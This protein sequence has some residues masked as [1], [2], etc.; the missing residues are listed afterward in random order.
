MNYAN[1][2][3]A[4]NQAGET[5]WTVLY[6][7]GLDARGVGRLG[8]FIMVVRILSVALLL[9]VAAVPVSAFQT[10]AEGGG[11]SNQAQS[12]GADSGKA[13]DLSSGK[14]LPSREDDK[15]AV[16]IPGLGSLGVLPKLDF[17]LELLYGDKPVAVAEPRDDAIESDP[18]GL[19][20]KGTFKHRF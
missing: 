13:L 1:C 18:D 16:R 4:F 20:I 11:V 17:G 15:S 6:V 2:S 14:E 9:G 7:E 10:G 5:L 19:R 3:G 8:I 12:A